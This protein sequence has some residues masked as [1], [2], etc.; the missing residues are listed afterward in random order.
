MS[1]DNTF[2]K[3]A[4]VECGSIEGLKAIL[5]STPPDRSWHIGFQ[6]INQKT[7]ID[8]AMVFGE[9]KEPGARKEPEGDE[10]GFFFIEGGATPPPFP[11]IGLPAYLKQMQYPFKVLDVMQ[12]D[13]VA[14]LYVIRARETG[15]VF[16][17]HIGRPWID[18]KN[19][20]S[21]LEH[22]VYLNAEKIRSVFQNDIVNAEK[23][24]LLWHFEQEEVK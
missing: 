5:R 13:K 17:D 24:L 18:E 11:D 12:H 20:V 21:G 22:L 9:P 10:I 8:P 23:Y 19:I 16:Q 7:F 14:G 1:E 6:P 15:K 3:F 2:K 4:V